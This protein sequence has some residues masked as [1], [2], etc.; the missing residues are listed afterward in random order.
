MAF[1]GEDDLAARPPPSTR[2]RESSNAHPAGW[3]RCP[4]G[5]RGVLHFRFLRT[6]SAHRLTNRADCGRPHLRR[7]GSEFYAA[8]VPRSAE[9]LVA[10]LR[11]VSSPCAPNCSRSPLHA[12]FAALDAEPSNLVPMVDRV[13]YRLVRGPP[14]RLRNPRAGSPTEPV[15]AE[16]DVRRSSASCAT[17]SECESEH[18]LG[19]PVKIR[20]CR[21]PKEP[22]RS[23]CANHGVA[24]NRARRSSS[25]P[26]LAGLIPSRARQ[27]VG[28]G[29]RPSITSRTLAARAAGLRRGG[30]RQGSQ[31]RLTVPLPVAG[32]RLVA[33]PLRLVAHRL[34]AANAEALP[35][36]RPPRAPR[37]APDAP[38]P[39]DHHRASGRPPGVPSASAPGPGPPDHLTRPAPGRSPRARDPAGP[40]PPMVDR[41]SAGRYR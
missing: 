11:P 13:V 40:A 30:A 39:S 27:T 7:T 25:Q 22:S 26:F 4:G 2:W 18:G 24:S 28:P 3:R 36:P 5:C 14:G 35:E 20:G 31:F 8:P 16:V 17:W 33:S 29:F 12:G 41:R 6:S 38:S 23:R 15:V 1:N 9:L 37:N 34:P 19:Q 21:A 32:D 10:E